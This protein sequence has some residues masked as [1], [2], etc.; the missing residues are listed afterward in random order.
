MELL[1]Q[2]WLLFPQ[3][4]GT[5]ELPPPVF[6]GRTFYVKGN[7]LQLKVR[8]RPAESG[9]FPWLVTTRL[10]LTQRW[11]GPLE[12]LRPGDHRIR[13]V[14]LRA[15]GQT[16]A[17]LPVPMP[18]PVEGFEIH[19][20]PAEVSWNLADGKLYGVRV[21]RFRYVARY[22]AQ[23]TPP[24]LEVDW[25]NPVEKRVERKW[26]P[27]GPYHILGSTQPVGT[28]PVETEEPQRGEQKGEPSAPQGFLLIGSVIAGLILLVILAR[29]FR[30][31]WIPWMYW[32]KMQA[33]LWSACWRSDCRQAIRVLVEWRR[34]YGWPGMDPESRQAWEMLDRACYGKGGTCWDGRR[35]WGALRR[36]IVL[37]PVGMEPGC[38]GTPLPPLWCTRK[39]I[40]VQGTISARRE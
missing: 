4:S 18:D 7:P 6:S 24:G 21:Q 25:W 27:G 12:G 1:E 36:L 33:R 16:G 9:D 28:A 31:V 8:P 29:Y 13:E 22:R 23:G 30:S 38:D 34:A 40:H 11:S 5:I 15:V 35:A 19:A 14:R 26:L 32:A 20:L 3:R 10:E 2:E 39:G 17:Q 37:L